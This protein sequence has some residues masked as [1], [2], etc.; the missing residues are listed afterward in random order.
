MPWS[1]FAT[2]LSALNAETPLGRVVSI[3][4][5]NDRDV[6]RSWPPEVRQIR[7]DWHLKRTMRL[8]Q[9]QPDVARKQISNLQALF[10]AAYGNKDDEK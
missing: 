2:L 5:E 6:I 10:K 8:K 7:T 3:R 9:N 4:T 1:E